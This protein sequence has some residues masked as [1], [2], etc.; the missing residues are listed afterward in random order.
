VIKTVKDFI[1][2]LWLWKSGTME[3]VPQVHWQTIAGHWR[4]IYLTP[5][6]GESHIPSY[7]RGKFLPVSRA[8]IVH[9]AHLNF[10]VSLKPLMMRKFCMHIWIQHKTY[11]FLHLL[12]F[13]GQKSFV[14]L[15][16]CADGVVAWVGPGPG[17]EKGQY[18]APLGIRTIPSTSP[19]RVAKSTTLSRLQNIEYSA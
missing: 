15:C 6:T 14:E 8:R 9:F 4:W 19:Y 16:Y 5:N 2:I 12:K 18:L 13:A 17:L 3:S 10:S 7:F 11:C 1:K